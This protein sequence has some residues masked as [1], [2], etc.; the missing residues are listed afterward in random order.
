MSV[1]KLGSSI[2]SLVA[3]SAIVCLLA[4]SACSTSTAADVEFSFNSDDAGIHVV[5]KNGADASQTDSYTVKSGEG[6]NINT[7]VNKGT[8]HV[9]VTDSTGK[10]VLDEDFKENVSKTVAAEG[11]VNVEVDAKGAD[12]TLNIS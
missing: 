6:L 11:S 9:K 4:L 5:A 8:F 1:R 12:G 10:A 3:I 7:V 2:A